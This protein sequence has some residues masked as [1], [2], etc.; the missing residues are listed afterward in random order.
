MD[1]GKLVI[2]FYIPIRLFQKRNIS[3]KYMGIF[4]FEVNDEDF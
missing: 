1:I 4:G 3:I 2:R